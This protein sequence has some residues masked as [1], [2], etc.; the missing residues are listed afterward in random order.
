[1][2][3]E[4]E[5]TVVGPALHAWALPAFLTT[6]PTDTVVGAILCGI[7]RVMLEGERTDWTDIREMLEKLREYGRE[8]TAWYHLLVP[9]INGFVR[10]FDA[11]ERGSGL[12][13]YHAWITA[14][15]VFSD[16]GQWI[17]MRFKLLDAAASPLQDPVSLSA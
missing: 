13:H 7:P 14:F 9:V 15:C 16:K 5:K 8:T 17:G 10:A 6:T 4:L 12:S 2:A 3:E 11:P 1:M